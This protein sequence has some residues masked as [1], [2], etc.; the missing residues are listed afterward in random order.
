MPNTSKHATQSERRAL[1]IVGMTSTGSTA[2]TVVRFSGTALSNGPYALATWCTVTDSATLGTT[3]KMTR[4]GKYLCTFSLP[5]VVAAGTLTQLTAISMDITD[6]TIDPTAADAAV[7]AI[8]RK[9]L[10]TGQQDTHTLAC[11]FHVGDT[12]V[13]GAATGVIRF[14][15]TN[16]AGATIVLAGVT[17]AE[18]RA[19][20][21]YLG[22]AAGQG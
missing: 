19:T 6:G 13:G 1:I 16:G 10:L 4:R 8:S 9:V 22:D 18:V 21:H 2:D 11:V 3:F 7:G 15:A 20:I 5:S 14:Q 17:L 12:L